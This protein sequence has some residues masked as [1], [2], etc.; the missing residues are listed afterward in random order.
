MEV[1][2][3]NKYTEKKSK[4][5]EEWQALGEEMT[6]WYG[7]NCYWIPH[8]YHVQRIKDAF[9]LLKKEGDTELTHLLKKLST[10]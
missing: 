6:E 10:K 8:K 4:H 9:F 5:K 2:D 1:P 7:K 3:L